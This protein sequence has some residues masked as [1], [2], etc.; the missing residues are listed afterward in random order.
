PWGGAVGEMV[1]EGGGG[2]CATVRAFRDFELLL[3]WRIEKGGDS[4]VYLRGV[5]QVQIWDNPVGSG[6]LYNNEKHPSRPR[7]VADR[8]V[9]EW[10]RMRIVMR[11]E[12][13]WVW[14]NGLLVVDGVVLEN[15]W[16]RGRPVY[17]EGPIELQAHGTPLRF[18]GVY[19][20]ELGEGQLP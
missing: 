4:G 17:E 9:G 3:S 10:N 20:R 5:P 11:G 13:A 15:Y 12:R 16:E 14:L 1:F 8:P 18:R 7:V 6:G 19:V 2:S